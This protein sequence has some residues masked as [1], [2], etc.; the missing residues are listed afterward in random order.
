M[1]SPITLSGFNNI[2]FKVVLDAIMEQERVPLNAL[3]E[4]QSSLNARSAEFAD[5]ATRL[6][7]LGSAVD[8]L[9]D[10]SA[11]GGRAVT[12]SDATAVS[13][14]ATESTPIGTYDV[15][16][17]ELARAQVTATNSSHSDADTTIV[18][19]GG[20]LTIG[21]TVVT[22]TGNVTLEGLRD[23][24]N[25]TTDVGVTAS[26]VSPSAGSYQLVLTGNDTGTT[27][28][29]T[30]TN[31][32][33]G[34][35]E[36]VTFI[37]FDTDGVSGDSVEDNAVQATDASATVNNITVTGS[38]NVLDSA[39]PGA[40]LTLLKKDPATTVTI[41][42]SQDLQTTKDRITTFVNA[43]NDLVGFFDTQVQAAAAGNQSSLGRDS[44]LRGLRTT[45]TTTLN[46]QY[47]VGGNYDVLAEVGIE[48][49]QDGTLSFDT[50]AFDEAVKT[51]TSDVQ[52]L[53]VGSGGTDGAFTV[54]AS[55]ITDY[56][57][58]GGLIPDAQSRL[59][60][61]LSSLATRILSLEDRLALRRQALQ[62]E[63]AAA[64]A[65]IKQL[66]NQSG[67][68]GSLGGQYSLF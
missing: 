39:I 53:F 34:G 49:Q 17:N 68:L 3:Q 4:Q 42:V 9:D 16:V 28:A 58:S 41:G 8:G 44:L 1:G 23:A 57:E 55:M 33:T 11:F 47:A 67:S 29:F 51:G 45:L 36:P 2:D 24:I 7:T 25:S 10:T 19:S 65:A 46:A 63:F 64:D 32:L 60:A 12:N 62:Q 26:I 59:D 40:T 27:K 14:T 21:G 48:F 38:T 22:V 52:K 61:Q 18:A 15:V 13:V 66:N 5:L 35:T 31:A 20:T 54:L 56:T 43:Y 37:D 50:T 6:G 30:I